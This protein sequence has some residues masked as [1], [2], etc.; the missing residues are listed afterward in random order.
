MLTAAFSDLGPA[1]PSRLDG[2]TSPAGT[3]VPK[4]WVLPV[5]SFVPF[6]LFKLLVLGGYLDQKVLPEQ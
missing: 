4:G 5:D 6:Y 1:C 3:S 2:A